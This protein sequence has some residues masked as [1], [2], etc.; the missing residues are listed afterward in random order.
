MTGDGVGGQPALAIGRSGQGDLGGLARD[1]IG[2]F[3]QVAHGID[4]RIAG[5]HTGVD[6]NAAPGTDRQTGLDC[7]R[8][9]R[10]HPHAQNDHVRVPTA[11]GLERHLK[12]W[13]QSGQ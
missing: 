4:V 11:A 12:T 10:P 6:A 3:D 7:Q 8:V 1:E 5:L 2:H 13:R 9:F